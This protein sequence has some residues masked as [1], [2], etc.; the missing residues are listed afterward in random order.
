M[1]TEIHH[2]PTYETPFATA[3]AS[4]R[5]CLQYCPDASSP[6]QCPGGSLRRKR[7][8]RGYGLGGVA[9]HCGESGHFGHSIRIGEQISQERSGNL[10]RTTLS[11]A[12]D[13]T[14]KRV[15]ENPER[16]CISRQSGVQGQD[17]KGRSRSGEGSAPLAN[18]EDEDWRCVPNCY[19]TDNHIF[20]YKTFV[21]P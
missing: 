16:D 11:L 1:K 6:G 2:R 21:Q 13:E 19:A 8:C 4:R 12:G 3:S 18:A 9:G 20:R 7:V 14:G 17:C 5:F 15:G 10:R